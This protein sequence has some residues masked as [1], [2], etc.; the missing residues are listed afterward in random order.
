MGPTATVLAYDLTKY[1]YQ[2]VD[3][4]HTDIE[5]ELYLRNATKIIP[6]PYKYVNEAKNGNI[7]IS[8]ITDKNYNNQIIYKILN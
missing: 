4:G 2:A 7:N 3:I 8:D 5:Y 6:I 1:G